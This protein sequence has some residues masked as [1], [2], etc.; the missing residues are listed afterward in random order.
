MYGHI[1]S[2]AY[3]HYFTLIIVG[4]GPWGIRFFLASM[5][6]FEILIFIFDIKKENRKA[7]KELIAH[8]T[9]N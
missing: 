8:S 3:P 7:I 4:H 5:L 1:N 2:Q 9:T 6:H